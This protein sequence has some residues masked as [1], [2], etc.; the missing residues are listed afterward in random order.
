MDGI[1]LKESSKFMYIPTKNLLTL[2]LSK[3]H[4]NCFYRTMQK[5]V[6]K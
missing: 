5:Y 6:P 4:G 3:R 2:Y 1:E